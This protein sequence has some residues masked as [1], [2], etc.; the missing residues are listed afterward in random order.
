MIKKLSLLF[1]LL[2]VPIT[3]AYSTPQGTL[4]EPSPVQLAKKIQQTYNK[5]KSLRFH[6][7]QK[8]S[9]EM[10]GRQQHGEGSAVFLRSSTEQKQ[11][12]RW[13][14]SRPDEQIIISDGRLFFMYFKKLKQLIVSPAKQ[15]ATDLT[16]AFFTGTGVLTRDFEILP[17]PG[18][19]AL[20]LI[21]HTP[22]QQVAEIELQTDDNAIITKITI[23][24]HF[25][26]ITTLLLDAIEI[27]PL[28]G[29]SPETLQKLFSFTPPPGTEIIEQFT[30]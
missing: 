3:P 13:Q 8:T 14:Y 17:A 9:G 21:P 19:H 26:T 2:C 28:T 12:M 29:S 18:A 30:E 24:D 10:T 1:L 6:F 25:G 11:K 20:K 5:M 27:D 22:Q 7:L 15:L 16:Y 23:T 4:P